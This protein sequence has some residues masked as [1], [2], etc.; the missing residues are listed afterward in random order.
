[1][2]VLPDNEH[3]CTR[4]LDS[5]C[6]SHEVFLSGPLHAGLFQSS[7]TSIINIFSQSLLLV[8]RNVKI[9]VNWAEEEWM[10]VAVFFS[11]FDIIKIFKRTFF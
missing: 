3:L 11:R 5:S 7:S 10:I 8:I 4:F 6:V 1:M 2:F 9:I